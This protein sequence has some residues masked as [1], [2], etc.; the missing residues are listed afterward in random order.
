MNLKKILCLALTSCFL[1]TALAAVLGIDYGQQYIKAMVV[2]PQAPLEL[3]LSP[4]AKRKDISGLAIKKLF[5]GN[6]KQHEIERIYGST[7]GSLET[8]FPQNMALQLKPL[9]GKTINDTEIISDYLSKH[10]AVNITATKRNSLAITID[11]IAYPIEELL[12]MN[13]QEIVHRSNALLK[14]NDHRTRDYVDKIALTVPEYFDQKQRMALIDSGSFIDRAYGTYLVND[15]LSVATNFAF[16]QQRSLK[17]GKEYYFIIY[18]VGSGSIK[19][20]LVKISNPV[21][22]T[23]SMT[24]ENKGYGFAT[25]GGS[26]FTAIIANIIQE[27]FLEKYSKTVSVDQLQANPKSLAKINQLAEKMKMVLS[28]NNDA[29]GSIEG[30]IDDIDFKV[31]IS[32]DEFE[33]RLDTLKDILVNPIHNALA[34]Q[35][36]NK[37]G[38]VNLSQLDG[39]VLA[40]GSTRVPFVQQTLAEIFPQ[41]KILKNV[42]AD[43][44]AVNGVT[45]RGIKLFDAFK[46]KPLDIIERSMYNYSISYETSVGS[47]NETIFEK[48]T[49]YPAKKS[50]IITSKNDLQQINIISH[51]NGSPLTNTTIKSNELFNLKSCPNG[52]QYNV[53]FELNEIRI[54]SVKEVMTICLSEAKEE[55]VKKEAT[56]AGNSTTASFK[57]TSKNRLKSPVSAVFDQAG[58]VIKPLSYGAR[59]KHINRIKALDEADKKRFQLQ[60]AKN[61]LESS[62]Y[63]ARNFITE[64]EVVSNGPPAQLKELDGLSFKYL[65]WLEDASDDA[66]KSQINKKRKEIEALKKKIENYL[67]AVGE[68]LDIE[69]FEGLLE[70]SGNVLHS[71]AAQEKLNQRNL[72]FFIQYIGDYP[73]FNYTEEYNKIGLPNHLVKSYS[74]FNQTITSLNQTHVAMEN[75]ISTKA[76]DGLNRVELYELK[77]A[78]D[79]LLVAAEKSDVLTSID[80]YR[81]NEL[82]SAYHRYVRAHKRKLEKEKKRLSKESSVAANITETELYSSKT[83]TP[84]N[85]SLGSTAT[86]SSVKSSATTGVVH[87]EL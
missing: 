17:S 50:V 72:E 78:F 7:I 27:K 1:S 56:F 60:E 64:E 32:R 66:T 43:E 70:R 86:P 14:E 68:P 21:N 37:T 12:A 44:S 23:D 28:A 41:D 10:P 45:L 58:I 18:D 65:E 11:G 87:D 79:K 36:N 48:G 84:V 81:L 24:I 15:G 59:I 46:T 52:I 30:L 55:N 51:E 33:S 85:I 2:S 35:F 5:T 47:F 39:V 54:F 19:A 80:D 53:T 77:E 31:G 4:E 62:L 49:V 74:K 61:L 6:N 26:D 69:Q 16:K 57:K 82:K 38:S 8:R 25:I 63:D 83:S 3:V 67:K 9:L 13:L 22:T 71:I 73:Q 29:S 76:F 75:L 20:S 42:N 40:G 34:T